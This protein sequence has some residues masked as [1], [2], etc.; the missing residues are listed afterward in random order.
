MSYLFRN[1]YLL[2]IGR[3]IFD[4]T[5]EVDGA[6]KFINHNIVRREY[7]IFFSLFSHGNGN[8]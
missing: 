3:N 8:T 7:V 1:T 4:V 6:I 2:L 5:T